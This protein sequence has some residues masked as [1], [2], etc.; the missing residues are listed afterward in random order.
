MESLERRSLLSIDPFHEMK[1]LNTANLRLFFEGRSGWFR[2]RCK[3][4]ARWPGV[5]NEA[6][7]VT[8]HL[9]HLEGCCLNQLAQTVP[10]NGTA[11]EVGSFKGRSAAYIASAFQ[12]SNAK[13]YCVDTWMSQA[14]SQKEEDVFGVFKKNTQ[15]WSDHIVPMRGNSQEVAKRWPG[16]PIDFLWIDGDH[17]YE[18]CR[19]DILSWLPFVREGAIVAFHD[20]ANPC[21]VEQ[22]VEELIRPRC[23]DI[24]LIDNIFAGRLIR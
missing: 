4:M 13:L 5:L 10:T 12:P 11:L 23:T 24:V 22:A 21:G 1:I 2:L 20:Y 3:A 8:G 18:G 14:M 7:Q 17:S 16:T 6:K 9:T 19:N 15:S